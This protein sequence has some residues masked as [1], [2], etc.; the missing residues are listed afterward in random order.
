MVWLPVPARMSPSASPVS[1]PPTVFRRNVGLLYLIRVLFWAHFFAAVMVPFYTQWGGLKLSQ[2]LYLNA[3][4][5]LCSFL[6]EVPTG[7]VADFLGRKVSLALGGL[8]AAAGAWFY[9]TEPSWIRFALAEA[10]LAVAFTLHSGADEALAYDSLKAD[11]RESAAVRVLSRLEACK[12]IGI[13]LGSL[14]GGWIALQGGLTAPMR[15]YMIPALLV[16]GLSLFLRE[17]PTGGEAHTRRSYFRILREGG[18]YF[19]SHPVLKLLSLELAVTNAFAWSIIWLYQPVVQA[20]G[21]PL[22]YFGFVHAGACVAQILFLAKV[23]TLQR[24]AGSRERLLRFSTVTAGAALLL[25]AFVRPL[26]LVVPL[27]CAAFAFSL[28]RVAIYTAHFN[29]LIPSDKRATVLSFASMVRTLAIVVFNPL[30]GLLADWSLAAT[31]G[32]LG[33]LLILLPWLSRL[34]ERHLSHTPH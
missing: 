20:R 14:T 30:T 16:F 29:T 27:V 24:W 6:L 4:F 18:R 10:L 5:M 28:P 25:L 11:G 22:Q 19:L 31:L 21:L 23:E 8:V 15:A 32:V 1:A 2:V 12:L 3:W 33:G 13:N 9:V 7:T 26:P 17:A 34:E